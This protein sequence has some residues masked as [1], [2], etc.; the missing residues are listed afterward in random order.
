MNSCHEEGVREQ[1][2]AGIELAD[3]AFSEAPSNAAPDKDGEPV[4]M[5]SFIGCIFCLASKYRGLRALRASTLQSF[6]TSPRT[7]WAA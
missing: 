7:P 6:G 2:R 5:D 1:N 4:P 3:P